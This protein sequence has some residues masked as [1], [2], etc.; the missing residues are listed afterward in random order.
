MH[1]HALLTYST[2]KYKNLLKYLT[3]SAQMLAFVQCRKV[4]MK[5]IVLSAHIGPIKI[6][7]SFGQRMDKSCLRLRPSTALPSSNHMLTV[8]TILK[9]VA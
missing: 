3:V 4:H 6:L 9:F 7:I 2:R 5:D 8:G 1:S